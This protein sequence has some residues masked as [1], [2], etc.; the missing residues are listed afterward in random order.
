VAAVGGGLCQLANLLYL[1]ALDIDAAVVERHH[2]GVDLFRD[3]GRTVPFG[4]GATVFYN[5]LDLR[6]RNALSFPV[7]LGVRVEPPL[8]TCE[9]RA[10]R[11][12]PF[13]VRLIETD[14]RFFR[15][16]GVVYRANRV[17]REVEE[18]AAPTHAVADPAW[19]GSRPSRLELLLVNES[20]V[21][22]EADDLVDAP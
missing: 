21:L 6:F 19:V 7:R 11:P 13:V 3:A 12:L 18:L 14:H 16:D 20:R 1:P 4:V 9:M 5:Y 17:W 15:R 10:V 22:Y 2:H 8:L